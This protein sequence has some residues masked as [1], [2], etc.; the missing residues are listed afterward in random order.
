M[1]PQATPELC[2]KFPGDDAEALAVLEANFHTRLRGFIIRPKVSG[3][4]PT[5][6]EDDAIDYLFHE[7]DWGYSP[8][9]LEEE[10]TC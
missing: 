3:Y 2:A 9:T 7:W 5:E 6:R 1:T 4:K 8:L 10:P